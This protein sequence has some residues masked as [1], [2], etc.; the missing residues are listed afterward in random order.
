VLSAADVGALPASTV[1]PSTSGL[2]TETYVNNAVA[3]KQN[4][5]YFNS[6]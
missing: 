5:V 2:A 4:K 6:S 1:I 3:A